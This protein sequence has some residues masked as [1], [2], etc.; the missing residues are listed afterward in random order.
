M[1]CI[2]EAEVWADLLF[3]T[4]DV[5]LSSL[6]PQWVGP[7]M[8]QAVPGLGLS[9]ARYN[10][11]GC[12]LDDEMTGEDRGN[13]ARGWFAE[14]E[15]F[16]PEPNGDFDWSRDEAQRAFLHLAVERGVDQVELFANSPMWWMTSHNSSFGGM[17]T[18]PDEFASYLA[19]VAAQARSGW[20]VPVKSVAPFNE[21]SAQWWSFP[22]NQ[23]GCRVDLSKQARVIAR[24]R[25]E[26]D[27][28]GL[29][30]VV[31]A[32]SDENRPDHSLFT[33]RELRRAEVA[34]STNVGYVGCLNVHS[35]EAAEPW[36]EE[37]HPGCRAAVS[38]LASASSIPIAVSEHGN[39][40]TSG[41]T[42]ARIIFEDLHYF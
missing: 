6:W 41:A 7:Y 8:P 24:L 11:G 36:L 26:L 37:K 34:G 18:K 19:E 40:D 13:K 10:I 4:E 2:Q 31:I 16:Q 20:R 21:P 1:G 33:L 12:G 39:G 29:S 5:P 30:D 15:G 27:R 38:R 17:L 25:D 23:E 3:S 28:R 35:Y 42:L 22:H 32:A 9:I 14:I